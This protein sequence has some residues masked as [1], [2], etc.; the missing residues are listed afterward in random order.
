MREIIIDRSKWRTATHGEGR[1]QLLNE[2]GYKCCLGFICQQVSRRKISENSYPCQ[3]D[4][5]VKGLSY[6]SNAFNKILDTE[7]TSEAIAIN[8]NEEIN[9]KERE[10]QLKELFKK[11]GYYKLK[12]VGR[13]KRKN[14]SIYW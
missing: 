14:D 2:E 5:P 13:Y 12:F 8:D 3:I 10:K 6:K 11:S 7:L 1:T 9:N 4:R